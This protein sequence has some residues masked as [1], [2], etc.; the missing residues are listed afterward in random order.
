MERM[1]LR[2][3]HRFIIRRLANLRDV[4]RYAF[5][6]IVLVLGLSVLAWWQGGIAASQYRTLVPT[7]NG[8]YAEGV[9]GALD[10]LNPLFASTPAE[11]AASRLLFASLLVRDN[12]NGLTG[13]LVETWQADSE[14]RNYTVTLRPG[15]VWHDGVPLTADDVVFTFNLIKNADTR[16]PLY[17]S[18]RN[19]G[20]K[21]V[22]DR[23]VSFALPT[24]FAAFADS[25]T[26][27]VVPRH[28]LQ[29]VRP[30]ELR[31]AAYNR[32]PRVASGPFMFQDLR[33]ADVRQ[34]SYLLRMAANPRYMLGQPKIDSFHLHAY[35]DRES[36]T[37]A[38]RMHE[39]ASFADAS[40]GQVNALGQGDF[41][42]VNAPLFNGVYAFL[43]TNTPPLNDQKV[44]KALQLATNQQNIIAQLDN[45]VQPL[46]GPLLP[47]QLG[48]ADKLRQSAPN[49]AHARALLDEAGWKINADGVRQ[50]D[51]QQLRLQLI[52]VSSG[53]YPTVAEEL[54]AQ[55]R[56][57]GVEFDS[58]LIK[59]E[60]IQQNNIIPRAYDVLIYEIA[61]GRDP[62]VYAYWH[63]SQA[64]ERGLNL[65]NY[66]SVQVDDALSSARTT[67]N[68]ELRQ[69]KYEA[70]TQRW[71]EDVPAIS[72][73]RPALLYVQNQSVVTF[74]S[75]PLV[76]A[77][78]RYVNVRYW[79][80]GR[81]MMRPTR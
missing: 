26:M 54:M 71:L 40:I 68:P 38:F 60:D 6:W 78:D 16:S 9:Y 28:I 25:L 21:K 35:K 5:G 77:T 15:V 74:K 63:S 42:Q 39:V 50:K 34:E 64:N 1:T 7:E 61:L 8:V 81:D 32:S 73:Y 59:A 3:A 67:L 30:S 52:T 27:G 49:I 14:G 62:D 12:K 55:W 72:L 66:R 10:N 37:G 75:R 45:K 48:Y 69:A 53:D 51:G 11:R 24:P 22:N 65:S 43:R 31:T 17:V 20:V 76:D 36:L 41:T 58:L 70:F 79:A 80:A 33:S 23:T 2:H 4:Q 57:I 18:W 29:D 46:D 47:G 56:Q 19:I 44:R 13:E